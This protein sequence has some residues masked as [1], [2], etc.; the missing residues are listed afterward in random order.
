MPIASRWM[1]TCTHMLVRS[2]QW[3]HNHA[4]ISLRPSLDAIRNVS[5]R[6]SEP[7]ESGWSRLKVLVIAYWLGHLCWGSLLFSSA[8]TGWARDICRKQV[9]RSYLRAQSGTCWTVMKVYYVVLFNWWRG[10]QRG[11]EKKRQK[12]GMIAVRKSRLPVIGRK[13]E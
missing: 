6:L 2:S 12:C 10:K 8:P 1:A 11:K 5:V 13:I 3:I 4:F 7:E 9:K